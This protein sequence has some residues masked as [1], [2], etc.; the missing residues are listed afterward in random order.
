IAAERRLKLT[1]RPCVALEMEKTHSPVRPQ[2]RVKWA[3]LQG[4]GKIG[5]G[6][7]KT[8]Q[9]EERMTAL[10]QR[11]RVV[12]LESESLGAAGDQVFRR[13]RVLLEMAVVEL[14]TLLQASKVDVDHERTC[15]FGALARIR[16]LGQRW[17]V[18]VEAHLD[19]VAAQGAQVPDVHGRAVVGRDH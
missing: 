13:D 6:F 10:V 18:P 7:F 14:G 9:S 11:F 12:R 15:I 16:R 4:C 3:K 17:R 5:K 1:K 8:L 19:E 2:V